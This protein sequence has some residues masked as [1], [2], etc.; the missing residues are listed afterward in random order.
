[1]ATASVFGANH[2]VHALAYSSVNL[3][4]AQQLAT[5]INNGVLGGSIATHQDNTAPTTH[6]GSN[7]FV[8]T[9]D[10]SFTLP[11]YYV[12]TVID[13][14]NSTISGS[15]AAHQTVLGGAANVAFSD[16]HRAASGN[17]ALGDGNNSVKIGAHDRGEW[18]ISV[19]NGND[20]INA[21]S[22]NT[23]ISAGS[24][25]S[26]IKLGSGDDVVRT[27]GQSTVIGD[28]GHATIFA[29]G[30]SLNFVGGSGSANVTGASG[31][32]NFF[33][34]GSGNETLTG[35]GGSAK[36][37]SDT[38]TFIKGQAGGHDLIQNFTAGDIVDLRG[39][40][41]QEI[42]RA[43]A[44]ATYTPQ[45]TTVVLPDQTTIT[46]KDVHGLN[47]STILTPGGTSH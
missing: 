18:S 32:A 28:G 27:M 40:S 8:Q 6:G 42:D 19:G 7:E 36:G 23:T 12:A 11:P 22:G 39:Y 37:G 30:G 29:S 14:A 1:M 45:G 38:F 15:S 5:S 31:E 20:T 17:I 10:G 16:N 4:L 26:L 47:M 43:V 44:H 21:G 33:Q 24:G 46:F 41:Q 9:Q 13:T 34:A 2:E 35:G 3:S 25:K